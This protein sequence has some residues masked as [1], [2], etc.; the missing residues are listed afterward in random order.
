MYRVGLFRQVRAASFIAFGVTAAI[1][2]YGWRNENTSKPLD[3]E[4]LSNFIIKISLSY[5]DN[6]KMII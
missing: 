3:L 4:S 6:H 2:V 5:I 1:G